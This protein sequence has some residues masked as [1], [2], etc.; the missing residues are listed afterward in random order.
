MRFPLSIQLRQAAFLRFAVLTLGLA[1]A[2]NS[3]HAQQAAEGGDA[4]AE[5]SKKLAN[6][7]ANLIS[8]PIKLDWDTG[9]G[10]AGA[11]RSVFIIQP[12]IPFSIGKDWNLITR[13]IIPYIVAESPLLGSLG[14]SKA[15]GLGDITQSFFFSPKAP[16]ANGL[17]W[18]V[19]PVLY[20]P[21]A[22][23]DAFATKKWGGGPTALLLKQS[24]GWTRGLLVNHIWSF[25]GPESSADFSN[26]FIQPFLSYT[27]KTQTTIGLNTE[28]TYG[29]KNH[30]WSV[31]INLTVAQLVRFG[32]QPVSFTLGARSYVAGPTGKPDWG[33]RLVVTLLFPK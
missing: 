27:T 10:T 2:P 28:S 24:N 21:T 4:A 1:L 3:V 7:V 19:G 23:N 26:T 9:I 33:L 6:P 31:P 13:T 15:S 14:G 12:V 17:I 8:V 11:D 25:G 20:Y 22:S 30:E 5:L 18:A 16:T 32:K 29:W